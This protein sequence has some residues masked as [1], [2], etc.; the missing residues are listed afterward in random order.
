MTVSQQKNLTPLCS[1]PNGLNPGQPVPM[2]PE[3]GRSSSHQAQSHWNHG[4]PKASLAE[5]RARQDSASCRIKPSTPSKAA[6]EDP[7]ALELLSLEHAQRLW[8]QYELVCCARIELIGYVD[9]ISMSGVIRRGNSHSCTRSCTRDKRRRWWLSWLSIDYDLERAR[10]H[11]ALLTTVVLAIGA[12][13]SRQEELTARLFEHARLVSQTVLAIGCRRARNSSD[14]IGAILL[15]SFFGMNL[16]TF[17]ANS[18]Q[19]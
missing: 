13:A 6:P 19:A 3:Q 14:M 5:Y 8:I 16:L 7:I 1:N 11:S 18:S 12:R 10:L 17:A 2:R 4:P 9:T 15:S